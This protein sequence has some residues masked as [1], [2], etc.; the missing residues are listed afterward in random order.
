MPSEMVIEATVSKQAYD[1]QANDLLRANK[2]NI[3]QLVHW[4]N[5]DIWWYFVVLG[6]MKKTIQL[7]QKHLG[8]PVCGVD[9][10]GF[11]PTCE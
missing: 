11:G 10:T 1:P 4:S 9:S 7:T 5:M 8:D 6:C 3:A 2:Y